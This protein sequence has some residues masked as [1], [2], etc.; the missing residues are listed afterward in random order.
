ML[1]AVLL[2]HA[3]L[4]VKTFELYQE[5]HFKYII[6]IQVVIFL[7][8]YFSC[9]IL[10]LTAVMLFLQMISFEATIPGYIPRVFLRYMYTM[11]V[12]LTPFGE[13]ITPFLSLLVANWKWCN[14][15][16]FFQTLILRHSHL[17]GWCEYVLA[18]LLVPIF[19]LYTYLMRKNKLSI[20]LNIFISTYDSLCFFFFEFFK[21]K[22]PFRNLW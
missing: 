8:K 16:L 15:M 6:S 5:N 13:H 17:T 20:A 14:A 22:K 12:T 19:N 21:G 1:T 3:I 9:I 10:S 11:I 7:I 18:L 4:T 2:R